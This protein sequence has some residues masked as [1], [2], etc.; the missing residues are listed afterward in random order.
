MYVPEMDC[1]KACIKKIL[2]TNKWT[3]NNTHID[4]HTPF[5][6]FRTLFLLCT[7]DQQEKHKLCRGPPNEQSTK[8]VSNWPSGFREVDLNVK[9]YGCH[10]RILTDAKWWQ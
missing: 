10:R 2:I 7:S 3:I 6:T 4:G 8:F 9:V 1:L 5:D